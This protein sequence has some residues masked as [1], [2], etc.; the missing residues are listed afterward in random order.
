MR[1]GNKYM[2]V[3]WRVSE[4]Y[5]MIDLV[6]RESYRDPD[7]TG[8]VSFPGKLN[9]EE[10]SALMDP[11]DEDIDDTNVDE[12]YPLDIEEEAPRLSAYDDDDDSFDGGD[13]SADADD[14]VDDFAPKKGKASGRSNAGS[15]MSLDEVQRDET[16]KNTDRD[17]E[18]E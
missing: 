8:S 7:L 13:D 2:A 14:E 1:K 3:V 18:D 16:R 11:I 10:K 12:T 17:S 4:H 15:M 9:D 5:H 6:I